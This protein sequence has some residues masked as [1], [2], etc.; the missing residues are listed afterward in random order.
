MS[1][2]FH[3]HACPRKAGPGHAIGDDSRLACGIAQTTAKLNERRADG[4]E[5]QCPQPSVPPAKLA[6]DT[7]EAAQ[8]KSCAERQY[9]AERAVGTSNA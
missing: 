8:Q 1:A 5:R 2:L 6:F 4:D 3:G 7:N 9:R